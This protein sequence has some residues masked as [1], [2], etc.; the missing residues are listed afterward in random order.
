M[1][2]ET[3]LIPPHQ[4]L[5][6]RHAVSDV[7]YDNKAKTNTPRDSNSLS[8]S[9][10]SRN[11]NNSYDSSPSKSFLSSHDS[12]TIRTLQN[13]VDDLETNQ[14]VMAS[15]IIKISKGQAVLHNAILDVYVTMDGHARMQQISS[16]I[17]DC[18]QTLMEAIL[19]NDRAK[20]LEITETIK[21]LQIAKASQG[22]ILDMRASLNKS[23]FEQI[24]GEQQALANDLKEKIQT[25]ETAPPT[26]PVKSIEQENQ[27]EPGKKRTIITQDKAPK[28]PKAKTPPNPSASKK[29]TENNNGI[30]KEK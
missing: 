27:E 22:S 11:R 21:T 20:V 2:K 4:A 6:F 25:I 12:S 1:T 10:W 15:S 28:K 26:E 14:N 8:M 17:S 30:F 9:N 3:I 23:T 13:R 19:I 7:A 29:G 5:N 16:F 18:Q 24:V